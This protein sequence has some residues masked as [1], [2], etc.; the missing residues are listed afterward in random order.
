MKVL[1]KKSILMSC[2]LLLLGGLLAFKS[3]ATITTISYIIGTALIAAGSFALVR[4]M[5][6][7]VKG[8]IST[9]ELDILYGTVSIIL[10]VLVVTH[11]TAIAKILPIVLGISIILSSANK[12]QYAFNLKNANNELWKMTMIIALIS[13][14]CG[15]VLLFNPFAA[16]KIIMQIV[17]IF[18]IVYS[19]LDIISTIIIKKYV[20]EFE[21]EVLIAEK[22]VIDAEVVDE[23]EEKKETKKKESTTKKKT[24]TK[25]ETT[26]KKTTSKK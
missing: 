26:K 22:N 3:E 8:E 17:G 6:N 12:I 7:N 5:K 9:V 18:I 13:T 25:K 23:K 16:A 24:T 19:V 1:F 15:V 10:G 4:F 20:E 2:I 14:A 11:P 21:N